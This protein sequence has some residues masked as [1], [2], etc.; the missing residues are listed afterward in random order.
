[1]R[2][3]M[4]LDPVWRPLLALFGGT[5]GN[6]FVEVNAGSVRFHFGWF[7]DESVPLT[8]IAGAGRTAWPLLGGIGWRVATRRRIGLIGSRQGVVDVRFRSARRMRFVFIPWQCRGIAVSLED[9]DGFIAALR[10]A[11]APVSS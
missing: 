10:A 11:A 3:P 2:Y 6:S 7:F 9:P 5:P 4:R 8:E 1:M